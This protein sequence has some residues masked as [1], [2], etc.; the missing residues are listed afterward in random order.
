MWR[1]WYEWCY[2]SGRFG[3]RRDGRARILWIEV[4]DMATIQTDVI[5]GSSIDWRS[6]VGGAIGAENAEP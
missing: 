6:V 5:A 2:L 3:R 1:H 4:I